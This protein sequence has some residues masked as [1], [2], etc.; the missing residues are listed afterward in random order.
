M[1]SESKSTFSTSS[2][3]DAFQHDAGLAAGQL[4]Q[5]GV[6]TQ[7]CELWSVVLDADTVGPADNFFILGGDSLLAL[8]LAAHCQL[9]VGAVIP[10]RAIFSSPTPRDLAARICAGEFDA[11]SRPSDSAVPAF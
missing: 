5:A 8:E 3:A 2:G 4:S 11:A 1:P 9:S 10:L 7:L 6:E